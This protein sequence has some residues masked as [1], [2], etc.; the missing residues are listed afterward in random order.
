[1]IKVAIGPGIAEHDFIED[2]VGVTLKL[3]DFI[4][5]LQYITHGRAYIEG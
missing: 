1:M 5:I 3:H 2:S 4:L